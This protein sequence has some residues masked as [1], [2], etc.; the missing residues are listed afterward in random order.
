MI[1]EDDHLFYRLIDNPSQVFW[2]KRKGLSFPAD[3]KEDKEGKGSLDIILS[4]GINGFI[5]VANTHETG[6]AFPV[7]FRRSI[8]SSRTSSN[9]NSRYSSTASD[10]RGSSVVN[11]LVQPSAVN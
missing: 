8:G 4:A 3:C 1:S 2:E 5:A 10:R 9:P 11:C 7:H 6:S